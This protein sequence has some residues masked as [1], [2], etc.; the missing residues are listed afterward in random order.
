MIKKNIDSYGQKNGSSH[1]EDSR[2]RIFRQKATGLLMIGLIAVGLLSGCGMKSAGETN[3]A[4]GMKPG[5]QLTVIDTDAAQK[6]VTDELVVSSIDRLGDVY[7]RSWLSDEELIVERKTQLW[8]HNVETD[9][10]RILTP[11]RKAPQLLA[12]VSPDQRHVFFTEGSPNSKYDIQGYILELSS[13]KVTSIGKLDMTNEVSWSDENHLITG[14]PDGK[15]QLIGLD[16][17]AEELSFQDPNR[18]ELISH[19]EKVGNV[20]FYTGSDKQGYPVLN[21]FTLNHPQA[22]TIAEGVMSFAVSPDGKSFAIEKRKWN[23]SEPARMIILDEQGKEKGIVGQGTLMSRGSWSSDGSKLAY[24]IYDEDQQG[25]R[26]L[27]VFDQSTGKTTPV[28]TDI[29]SYDSPTVWSPSARFLSM[30][31]NIS[32]GGKQL[33][34]SYIVEFKRK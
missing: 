34:Q 24:S 16:G 27:Y 21:R 2:T 18:S 32:E 14:T 17:K 4:F 30:Y 11:G 28:T 12:V 8:I 31:Q 33:N 3:P 15:I 23:T 25:M 29:Q 9:K 22:V 13:G 20:I 26:G 10:E 1:R 6:Q 19:V 7:A 5:Q